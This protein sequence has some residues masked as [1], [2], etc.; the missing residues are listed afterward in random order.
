MGVSELFVFGEFKTSC[1]YYW[2]YFW[3]VFE[4]VMW[5]GY[6]RNLID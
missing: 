6:L 3:L 2:L 1:A 4:M 5:L